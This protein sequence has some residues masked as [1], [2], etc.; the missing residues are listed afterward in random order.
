MIDSWEFRNPQQGAAAGCMDAN[1]S[2]FPTLGVADSQVG[3]S[4]MGA[5]GWRVGTGARVTVGGDQLPADRVRR[6]PG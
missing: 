3:S 4:A 5:A 2:R 6:R 1:A